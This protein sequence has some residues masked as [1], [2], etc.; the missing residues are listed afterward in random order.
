M[1]NT[2]VMVLSSN[3]FSEEG[4]GGR[5]KTKSENRIYVEKIALMVRKMLLSA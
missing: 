2:F 1:A 5:E 3:H 4:R